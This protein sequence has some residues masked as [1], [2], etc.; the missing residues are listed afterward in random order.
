M[1]RR[2]EL[3]QN[4]NKLNSFTKLPEIGMRHFTSTRIHRFKESDRGNN[5]SYRKMDNDNGRIFKFGKRR[6]C[7]FVIYANAEK[8]F[9]VDFANSPGSLFWL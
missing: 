4:A 7:N 2:H 8:I 1:S 6:M 5:G 9:T 3:Y